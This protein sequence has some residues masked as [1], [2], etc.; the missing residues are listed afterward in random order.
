MTPKQRKFVTE[1]LQCW[2]ASE[3]ARRAGYTGKAN[4]VGPRLL[5]NVS[6]SAEIQRK[7]DELAMSADEALIRL[8]NQAR[9]SLEHFVSIGDE[10]QFRIDLNNPNAD[11]SLI[12]KLKH[13]QSTYFDKDGGKETTNTYEFELHDA[14]V[15]LVY[16][17]KHH[18]LFEPKEQQPQETIQ[19]T[20]DQWRE[21]QEARAAK[22]TETK[23][24]FED[25]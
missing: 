4:V 7:V 22:A 8:G 6:I 19:Y 24:I 10:G 20:P 15:A 12:K 18:G 2:N 25:V 16:I 13:K 21:E 1:Y 3:A 23:R 9:G 11:L 14:Q 5:A 17:N